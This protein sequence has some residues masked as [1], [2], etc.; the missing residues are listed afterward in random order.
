MTTYKISSDYFV[1]A[2]KLCIDKQT[3]SQWAKTKKIKKHANKEV[4]CTFTIDTVHDEIYQGN[5]KTRDWEDQAIKFTK[6]LINGNHD[7]DHYILKSMNTYAKCVIVD[8]TANDE[9]NIPY[10]IPDNNTNCYI[11]DCFPGVCV[12][13][14]NNLL[15]QSEASLKSFFKQH[16]T[17]HTHLFKNPLNGNDGVGSQLY[18][19]NDD[20][21]LQYTAYF[22]YDL[23]MFRYICHKT[24]PDKGSEL[25][26]ILTKLNPLT[27]KDI[28]IIN[29]V[30]L[31]YLWAHLMVYCKVCVEKDLTI[32]TKDNN[33]YY[34]MLARLSLIRFD[35]FMLN[36]D[37]YISN[38]IFYYYGGITYNV[39]DERTATYIDKLCSSIY[40]NNGCSSFRNDT[41]KGGKLA[42]GCQ[43]ITSQS[44]AASCILDILGSVKGV[45]C[46]NEDVN[47]PIKNA[48]KKELSALMNNRKEAPYGWTILKFSGDS[49]HIVFGHIMEEIKNSQFEPNL[50][51][52]ITYL[53]SERP[54][55]GRLLAAGKTILYKCLSTNI[56]MKDFNGKG[57]EN[58]YDGHAALYITI[59]LKKSFNNI[60][61]GLKEKIQN[62]DGDPVKY[63]TSFKKNPPIINDTKPIGQN[64][65]IENQDINQQIK[66]LLG[67]VEVKDFLEAYEIDELKSNIETHIANEY[68][69]L[70]SNFIGKR[71]LHIR[72]GT[73]ANWYTLVDLLNRRKALVGNEKNLIEKFD[74]IQKFMSLCALLVSKN[75]MKE[76]VKEKI[77]NMIKIDNGF[78]AIFEKIIK[79]YNIR[80]KKYIAFE[81]NLRQT[82]I[83]SPG[84]GVSGKIPSCIDLII[85]ELKQF[86][87]DCLTVHNEIKP[88]QQG[89]GP[90]ITTVEDKI[91]E[92]KTVEDKTVED[93]TVED[94]TV[95]DKTVEDKTVEDKTPKKAAEKAKID[96]PDEILKIESLTFI[97]DFITMLK[98]SILV[99][100]GDN[101]MPTF[102]EEEMNEIE[103]YVKKFKK[104]RTKFLKVQYDNEK[105]Q[106]KA[107]LN[108]VNIIDKKNTELNGF[109]DVLCHRMIM[110]SGLDEPEKVIYKH[111]EAIYKCYQTANFYLNEIFE[112][113]IYYLLPTILTKV[114][115]ELK[116]SNF[117]EQRIEKLIEGLNTMLPS[118]KTNLQR[119][120]PWID[121]DKLKEMQTEDQDNI[122]FIYDFQQKTPSN[123]VG[124][125][126]NTT[127]QLNDKHYKA[128]KDN[129]KKNLPEIVEDI[130]R[131]NKTLSKY[132]I[133]VP[134][135]TRKLDSMRTTVLDSMLLTLSTSGK[136]KDV[137]A[138]GRTKRRT[139]GRRTSGRRTKRRTS[140]HR[141]KH[142]TK[143][144]TSGVKSKRRTR[145]RS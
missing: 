46:R 19:N 53:V 80:D 128:M 35:G 83:N 29:T 108:S 139:S 95:E 134:Y 50:N 55:A 118:V 141:T 5:T 27:P 64:E 99:Y 54:L 67:N 97:E 78:K 42:G 18:N 49:S 47:D 16:N 62:V 122:K 37:G 136:K 142:R 84:K 11:K 60:I 31:N 66:D 7:H 51:F 106:K 43:Y 143:R 63:N 3:F 41:K 111:F 1:H 87:D 59:D 14:L 48:C 25:Q 145:R 12:P 85:Q 92:D 36:N 69:E 102:I 21:S 44:M 9:G 129:L 33:S 10:N 135:T 8:E 119:Q 89:G 15:D 114:K 113:K 23:L 17:P 105:E 110:V 137:Y 58:K 20:N 22:N 2:N 45:I 130:V 101:N 126:I 68:Q 88:V 123:D 38:P 52:E 96:E 112:E 144:R 107:E 93:K 39:I 34:N 56:F 61:E 127:K 86:I 125:N 138:G 90:P 115:E 26:T 28:Q 6:I 65:R 121:I 24:N 132:Q 131:C 79:S 72:I 73:H 30:N 76:F 109:V 120:F 81:Q 124:F 77:Q 94:K 57:S 98:Q 71:F 116:I 40:I 13:G 82:Y 4:C 70:A 104:W 100:I 133:L 74:K 140:G 32:T 103:K 75:G 91:V 117:K